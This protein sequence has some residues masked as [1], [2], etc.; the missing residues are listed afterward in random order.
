M[1]QWH[2]NKLPSCCLAIIMRNAQS[3]PVLLLPAWLFLFL[4]PVRLTAVFY[5]LLALRVFRPLF[6]W[7]MY[8]NWGYTIHCLLWCN[9]D[10]IENYVSDNYSVACICCGRNMFTNLLTTLRA[11]TYRHID[12]WGRFIKYGIEMVQSTM[13][14]QVSKVDW[15]RWDTQAYREQVLLEYLSKS[16]NRN[17][18]CMSPFR[19]LS[20]TTSTPKTFHLI[21]YDIGS[22]TCSF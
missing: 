1:S 16:T 4:S 7:F 11:Y 10:C 2:R 6:Q 5:C 15:G 9:M 18:S 20:T 14:Y 21:N 3:S 13:I 8:K 12:W 19:I 17:S 22:C